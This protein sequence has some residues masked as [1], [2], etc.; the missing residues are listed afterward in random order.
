MFV[1]YNLNPH[2]KRVGDCVIRAISTALN[3]EWDVVYIDLANKG[4]EMGDM[5]SSNSVW[6][7]YLLEQ[8]FEVKALPYTITI[9]RF[10]CLHP[11]GTYILGTGSHVVALIDGEYYD[12]WDSGDEIVIYYFKEE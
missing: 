7:C 6:G 2:G 1:E 9:R 8:G 12:T 4:L 10:A 11:E 3:R 5:P